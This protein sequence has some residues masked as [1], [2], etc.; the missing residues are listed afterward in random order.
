MRIL[1]LESSAKAASCCIADDGRLLAQSFQNNGLTHSRTLLPMVSD[2][3]KNCGIAVQDVDAIAAANGPGSFTGL[4]IGISTAKGLAWGTGKPI[5]AVS[6]LEA[7]AWNSGVR[8]GLICCVMD[9]R[10]QQVYNALFRAED[11]G[12]VRLTEDRAIAL[13]DLFRDGRLRTDPVTLVGD[14][15][16]L[17]CSY[18]LSK[19]VSLSLAPENLLQQ[20]AWGVARAA[21]K[22]IR[23][24][25]FEPAADISPN[26]LRLSQAE[27]ERL[28]K[29]HRLPGDAKQS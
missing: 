8:E 10:R 9:A 28:E 18:G 26:Y 13:E 25:G 3:L 1:A 4:R 11:A 19:G 24:E 29:Q 16:E 5:C 12:P 14:G 17:C 22:K 15:A 21:L 23:E 6:A 2:M 20:S 27:R 7:M